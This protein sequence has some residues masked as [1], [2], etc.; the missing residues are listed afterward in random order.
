MG[1]V[2]MGKIFSK[3]T[4]AATGFFLFVLLLSGM[5]EAV[6]EEADLF[7]KAYGYYLSYQP[8]KAIEAFDQF[9][10]R[11]PSSSA[12]DSVMFWRAKSLVQMK[13]IDEAAR[14]FS[15]MKERYPDSSY[16]VFA[17]KELDAIQQSSRKAEKQDVSKERDPKQGEARS[18]V[19]EEKIGRLESEISGLEKKLGDSEKL[20]QLTEKGLVKALDDKNGLEAQVE[21]ARRIREDLGRKLTSAEKSEKEYARLIE[22]RKALEAKLKDQED[23]LKAVS[24]Q[25]EH[26]KDRDK[27]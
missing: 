11:F 7:E 13:R 5:A 8:E 17:E 6:H 3:H 21:E 16:T 2:S 22:D 20:R 10:D 23:K 4:I 14:D 1:E 27:E 26:Q 15:L 18:S 19:Y 9:I 12:M 24:T 25:A